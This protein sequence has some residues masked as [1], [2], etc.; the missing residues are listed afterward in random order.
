MEGHP[1]SLDELRIEITGSGPRGRTY[2]FVRDSEYEFEIT[3]PY[4]ASMPGLLPGTAVGVGDRG[5]ARRI[6]QKFGR[7]AELGTADSGLHH[8]RRRPPVRFAFRRAPGMLYKRAVDARGPRT[9]FRLRLVTRD[10]LI[11][12]LPWELLYDHEIRHDFVCSIRG[13]AGPAG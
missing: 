8:G 10:P 6:P 4:G 3:A 13:V 1:T 7:A 12:A 11:T 2:E 9:E 5:R